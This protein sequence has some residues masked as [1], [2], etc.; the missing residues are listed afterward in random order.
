MVIASKKAAKHLARK[1]TGRHWKTGGGRRTKLTAAVFKA[2]VETVRAGNYLQTAA[3]AG[4]VSVNTV[5]EWI[6]RGENRENNGRRPTPLYARFAHAL[7]E[8]EAE[9]ERN[10]VKVLTENLTGYS[11]QVREVSEEIDNQGVVTGRRTKI[12]ERTVRDPRS[13]IEFLKRRFPDRWGDREKHK[14]DHE[15]RHEHVVMSAED[16]AIAS[17]IASARLRRASPN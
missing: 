4:G 11:S 5:S 3:G 16:R 8:A 13:A 15:H 7:R 14:H 1:K 2:V 9:A 12:T 17:R 10:A 6:R